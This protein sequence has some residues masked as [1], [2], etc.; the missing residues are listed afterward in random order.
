VQALFS[1]AYTDSRPYAFLSRPTVEIERAAIEPLAPA[2]VG[3]PVAAPININISISP[4]GHVI[5]S[6]ATVAPASSAAVVSFEKKYED[7]LDFSACTGFDEEFLGAYL[8]MPVPSAK[9]RK[10]LAYLVDS[11]KSYTLKYHHFSTIH[12]AVRRVPVVSALNVHAK[13]R[14]AELDL[15]GSRADKWYRDNRI[16]YDVQLDDAFYAKSGFDRGHLARR[17][18]AEWGR[19]IALAKLSADLTCTYAN[20]VPQVPAI[21]RAK[22]GAKGKWGLLE[23]ALLEKGIEKEAGKGRRIC[24]FS[25]PI[26][27]EDDPVFK[28]VQIAVDFFKVVVW[29][30]GAGELRT[31]CY[32]L[33][34]EKLVG[35]IEFE[36]LHFDE[37]FQT[38]QVPIRNIERATGLDFHADIADRDTYVE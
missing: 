15:E 27:H 3:P 13:W 22:F 9:L 29:Y 24:V 38:N 7:E 4:Y 23:I 18:D 35:Q 20:A 36:V 14:Y 16:D 2:L 10:K 25:G 12:H 5:T 26:F 34:Q 21:N 6:A 19:S 30:D 17:E 33:S 1:P 37:I 28:G 11:P 32:R 8:P 31:T